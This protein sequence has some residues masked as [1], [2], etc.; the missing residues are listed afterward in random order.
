[1]SKVTSRQI[2]LLA[3]YLEGDHPTHI[4][5]DKE[6]GETTR[7]WN[8]HCPLHG[9]ERRSASINLEKGLFWCARC[10][11]MPVT[12]LLRRKDDWVEFSLNGNVPNPDLG[13]AAPDKK[14]RMLS[15]G[16]I[17]GW[18]SALLSNEPALRWL[19]ERRGL[20]VQTLHR[21]EIGMEN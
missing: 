10:G 18:H 4:N 12:A 11:G 7:E 2:R 8:L 1:M 20:N 16:M 17:A 13:A 3:P 15:E 6:T 19:K 5:T 14:Q 21:Y 9:D